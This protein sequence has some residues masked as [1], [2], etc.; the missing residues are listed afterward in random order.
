MHMSLGLYWEI[1]DGID[2]CVVMGIHLYQ[3]FASKQQ[4]QKL[5]YY[6]LFSVMST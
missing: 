6:V 1:E 4:M 3:R 5:L 2:T